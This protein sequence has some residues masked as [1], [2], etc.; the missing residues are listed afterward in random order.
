MVIAL[1]I[2]YYRLR[3]LRVSKTIVTSKVIRVESPGEI[4]IMVD[5]IIS[6]IM[7]I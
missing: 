4:R 3:S 5:K 1:F 6:N 7:A 2:N